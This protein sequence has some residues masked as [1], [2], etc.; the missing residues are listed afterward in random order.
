MLHYTIK[1]NLLQTVSSQHAS[2]LYLCVL[3]T[4]M[5]LFQRPGSLQMGDVGEE[6]RFLALLP[7]PYVPKVQAW[8]TEGHYGTLDN[9]KT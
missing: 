1:R 4:V 9:K 3:L 7:K 2:L 8:H 6:Q 5:H